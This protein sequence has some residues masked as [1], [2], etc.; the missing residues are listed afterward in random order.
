MVSEVP[1]FVTPGVGSELGPP[2]PEA[3][4]LRRRLTFWRQAL[5]EEESASERVREEARQAELLMVPFRDQMDL[6][7]TQV[8]A[9]LEQVAAE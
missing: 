6:Q 9:G 2:E 7:W 8:V 4:R 3:E 5:A 1:L